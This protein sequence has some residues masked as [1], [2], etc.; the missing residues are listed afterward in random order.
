MLFD[1]KLELR[2]GR[3]SAADQFASLPAFGLQVSGGIDS[4]P[5][6]IFVNAPFTIPPDATWAASAMVKVTKDI[7]AQ[8]GIYQASDLVGK[9]AYHGL[10]FA[11][12]G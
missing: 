1:D 11:I 3:M 7:Y 5:T 10:D 6:S 8:A 2:R 4:N 12:N 9:T